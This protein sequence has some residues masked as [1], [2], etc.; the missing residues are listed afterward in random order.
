MKNII[1]ATDGSDHADKAV[2]LASDL[3][4]RYR[5]RLTIL[6]NYLTAADSATLRKLANRRA[7]GSGLSKLLDTYEID[8]QTMMMADSE[9][10]PY[11]I[12]APRE[13][14]EAIGKQIVERAAQRAKKA[15]V[16]RV[17]TQLLG[18]DPADSILVQAK[19]S[20][21]DTIILGSR[22]LSDLKGFFL[23]SV[24]HKVSAHATC[25]CVTVK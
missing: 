9:A 16:K 21:A 13:L 2:A 15:G 3:A 6:H 10:M 4:A 1:V 14:V 24:S 11:P 8:A 7:L 20:K 12:L 22:G 18:G 23:G 5:A 19:K 25:T 17:E